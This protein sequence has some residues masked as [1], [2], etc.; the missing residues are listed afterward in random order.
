MHYSMV[1][2]KPP[3]S[4]FRVI[5]TNFRESDFCSNYYFVAVMVVSGTDVMNWAGCILHLSF[6]TP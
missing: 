3:C 4:N 1:M 2:V 6:G 5:T